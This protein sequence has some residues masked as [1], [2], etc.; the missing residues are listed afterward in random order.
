MIWENRISLDIFIGENGMNLIEI[1]INAYK[2][3]SNRKLISKIYSTLQMDRGFSTM[4]I[5]LR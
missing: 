4:H 5:K 1:F 3:N 2:G